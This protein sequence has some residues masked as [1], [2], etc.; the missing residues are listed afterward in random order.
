M[1]VAIPQVITEDRAGGAQVID[2]G[3]RFDSGKSQYLSR[4][5]SAGNRKTWSL[6]FWTKRFDVG[7]GS[8]YFFSTLNNGGNSGTYLYLNLNNLR[9]WDRNSST[10]GLILTT[11]AVI[12]DTSSWYH[13]LLSVNYSASTN[14][15]RA[16]IYING[17]EQTYSA[18]SYPGTTEDSYTNANTTHY[19][20][21]PTAY[22]DG[23]ITQ[24]YFIDGQ[25]LDPS[26]FGY[27]DPLT[28]TWRPK[29]FKPQATPND[30]RTWNS[31]L[32]GT[33]QSVTD[34]GSAFNGDLGSSGYVTD[35]ITFTP[36]SFM[37]A[38]GYVRS[39]R[40][41]TYSFGQG[42]T[43]WLN[44]TQ[45][46]TN[47]NFGS[48]G[49]Y[50]F[51]M[52]SVGYT[53]TS[54]K[55]DRQPG[56][57]SNNTD[58][59]AA[60]EINGVILLNGDT[61]NMGAN[62]FYLPFDGNSP[63]GQDRSGRGN[64]WTPVNF[65]GSNTIE[66]ATGAL[67]ILNTDGGG[68]VARV[69]VRTDSNASSLVLALPL[70]GIKSDF[71]NAINSGTSNK[72]ISINGSAAASSAQSNFY[73]GSF[74]FNGSTD[75]LTVNY[76]SDLDFTG[77]FTLEGWVYPS[78]STGDHSVFGNF[79]ANATGN[80][81]LAFDY[82]TYGVFTVFYYQGNTSISNAGYVPTTGRWN[83]YAVTRD[84]SNVIRVFLNGQLLPTTATYSG[85]LGVSSQNT[86][87]AYRGGLNPLNG[88]IQDVRFYKGTAK[89]T[90]NFIPASTD[91]DILPDTPSGVA[92]SSNVALVPST[93]GAVAFDGSGDYL[94][95][96][97]SAD[98][99][100]GTGDFTF[101][102]FAYYNTRN[103]FSGIFGPYTYSNNAILIQISN[104][105]VLRLV[106]PSAIDVS[107]TTNL[108][109]KW[110]HIAVTRS[111]T[112][113]RGFINGIQ[114]ISTTYSSSI[115]FANGGAAVLGVTDVSTY[116]GTYDFRGFI[117]NLH[118]VKGTAL[119][120][121]N[122]TP[123]TA[124]ITS[125]ANT[126][127]LCCK[128]NSS[129]TAF[130]VSP[131]SITANGNTVATNFNPFTVNINTQ[132]GQ[133]SGWCT[134]NPLDTAGSTLSNGNLN[135]TTPSS[136]LGATRGTIGISSGK[137]Y[138]EHTIISGATAIG[139]MKLTDILV[140]GSGIIGASAGGYSYY[141]EGVAGG[142]YTK[143]I[144]NGTQTDYGASFDPGDTISVAFDLDAG[145]ITFYKNGISQGIAFSGLSGTFSAAISDGT[146]AGSIVGATNF[147]QKPFKFPPPAGFQPLALANTPRPT[148]VRPDQYVG[149]VT[150]T[151]TNAARSL[152]T[153]FKPDFVWIKVRGATGGPVIVDSVRGASAT[154][155]THATTQEQ[156]DSDAVTGFNPYGFSLGSGFTVVN[157]NNSSPNY[158][159]AW[160]WKA[161]GS[162]GGY[163]FWKDD[164]GYSTASAA[165]LTAG[166]ITPTGAS[167]NT[168][169]GF[170][171]ITFTAD[172]GTNIFS[173][174]HGL[175]STPKFVIV[176]SR[177]NGVAPWYVYH[178]SLATDNYLRLNGTNAAASDGANQ[179]GNGMTSSVIGLRAGYTTV[180]STATVA[181]AWAEIPG[182]SKFGS[183]TGNG[184]TDGPIV[185]T[186][187]R[188][189]WILV[190]H[191]TGS[192]SDSSNSWWEIYDTTRDPYNPVQYRLQAQR[193]TSEF[194]GTALIDVLS[195]GFKIRVAPADTNNASG[196]SYI[197]AAFA[198]TPSFNLYGGQSNAR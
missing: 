179:W 76:N 55:W 113:L 180:A 90:Q 96:G 12:R 63:I 62:A 39:C 13:I 60:I 58:Y 107:G 177:D 122:F 88:F 86:F 104:S 193:N 112:T 188:P 18:T 4:T 130:D 1:G 158:Y 75:Y 74:T 9:Y 50:S 19:I 131:G 189:K 28:N 153:G 85:T 98:Y 5:F 51:D 191:Y 154:L 119:Y 92:Y 169:S 157:V 36:P 109:N 53:L 73:G 79:L 105:S 49:W 22:Y 67:P 101:E 151:G 6:S 35:G 171:I 149:I 59:I 134:W 27:T 142:G 133:E 166:T 162:G 116:L 141:S 2:G 15:D 164:I 100:V 45:V 65:G 136:G 120:T 38:A 128:S 165:G 77:Q 156:A 152:I 118:I 190:K 161:G 181:Y 103:D 64:N 182:F 81:G 30:G 185:V 132:R 115:D 129:A 46:A 117:S 183:Y 178:S 44:G 43:I 41:Y 78:A 187:F 110:V 145:T 114:E 140:S 32:S 99:N 87:I 111:G 175:Q 121:A 84:A 138:Y 42:G 91:P 127:L 61:T 83:H 163:S 168:K 139:I 93:D 146:N 173:V 24:F 66:K 34:P 160:A 48:G 71:S 147:G 97:S 68:K 17:I 126:K 197:Y 47:Y 72:V 7:T 155:Q 184:S 31:T 170:S 52:A 16:K 174:P 106:N 20:A 172:S 37:S 176:K 26:S 23:S 8:K 143:K 102:C 14:T 25:A 167:V 150:Y 33:S 10:D 21:A 125:V 70:V 196:A 137:W 123:P 144:N 108:S 95:L 80:W 69:G 40:F 192:L 198:E 57:G 94:N 194:S 11:N 56:S 195:N 124:P 29:K 159:V 148:I 54:F 3:L 186:G 135:I 82:S 89:Y